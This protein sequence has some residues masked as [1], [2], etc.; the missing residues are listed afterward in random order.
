VKYKHIFFD[1][2]HTLWDYDANA[3]DSLRELFDR[4]GLNRYPNMTADYLIEAFFSVNYDLWSLYNN[5][6]IQRKDI[7]ERRFPTIFKRMGLSKAD[8]PET[9]EED[10][11]A[12][13]PT[14]SRTFPN[15]AE[16]LDYLSS[17][18]RLHIIT[19]GFNGI[20]ENKLVASGI[21]DFFDV[22]ITSESANQRKPNPDIFHLAMDQAGA[23]IRQAIMIGDNL[24]SDIQGAKNVGMDHIWF[25]PQKTFTHVEVQHEIHN[26][27]ELKSL[28]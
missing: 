22:I 3:S 28:L 14:K 8:M 1:L 24:A 15:A 10:Y 27:I 4:F 9:I 19:N 26:L 12:L 25:N 18:Y 2:D 7:R 16:V 21:R 20:Q 6:Q 23:D 13:C 11:V 5:H 17:K